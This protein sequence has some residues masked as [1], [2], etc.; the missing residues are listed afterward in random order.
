MRQKEDLPFANLLNTIRQKKKDSVLNTSDRTL[1]TSRCFSISDTPD[2]VLHV[3]PRNKDVDAF[4]NSQLEKCAGKVSVDAADILHVRGGI[5]KKRNTPAQKTNTMLR[6]N[7]DLAADARVMLTT[8]L[9]VSDGLCNG[10]MGTVKMILTTKTELGQPQGVWILFDNA[11]VGTNSRLLSPPPATLPERCVCIV[12][13]TEQFAFQSANITRHQ[14]PL[15]LAWACT[16]HKTQGMTLQ[17][18]VVCFKGTFLAG[19]QYV[20]ISRVTSIAG[21]YITDY[22]EDALYC[23]TKVTSALSSMVP[24][25]VSSTPLLSC[26]P[27][28]N[29]LTIVVH[30]IHSLPA[31]VDD[32]KANPEMTAADVI[33][34][35]ET[36]LRPNANTES[37]IIPGYTLSA[38]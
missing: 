26:P 10:V 5:V 25:R 35:C 27:R 33:G 38:M 30:N 32:L 34:L 23:D 4:N 20:A 13:H 21:L 14:Y 9:D 31:H 22:S 12:P 2:D 18:C 15:R 37:L 6:E 11:Q 24:L 17:Q 19:M 3:F 28:Q 1:L 16:V 29:S 7:V 36:W 8:N